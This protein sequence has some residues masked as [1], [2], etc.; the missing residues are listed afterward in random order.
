M[1]E[2]LECVHMTFD[3]IWGFAASMAIGR[4]LS[5]DSD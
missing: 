5:Y 3:E 4:R 1:G 2:V